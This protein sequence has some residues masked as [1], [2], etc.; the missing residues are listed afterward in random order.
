M[1]WKFLR[2]S[3]WRPGSRHHAIWAVL[4]VA[5]GTAIA[6][7]MLSVS[8]DIGDK[9]GRELRSLGAN[10][11]ITPAADSL[12]VEIGGIDY[13][14]VSEGAY[15]PDSSLPKL[16]EIFWRNNITAF[17]PF[18]YVPVRVVPQNG[19]N[20]EVTTLVGTWY[21]RPFNTSGGERFQTGVK[22]LNPSW[23]IAGS[24]IDDSA[25][26][27]TGKYCLAGKSLA[28]SLHLAPGDAV[29]LAF[30]E[31]ESRP[32][33]DQ[34]PAQVQCAI[35]GILTT[36]GEEDQQI[37]ST[38]AVA[39]SLAGLPGKTRKIQ[40][41]ALIKPEDPSSR[42]DIKAMT[43]AEYERWYCSPYISSILH[44][45]DEVLPGA[46]ARQI[47][48]VAE[49]EGKVLGKLEFLMVTLAVL[50]LVAAA[51]S[52]SSIATIRV[53]KRRQEISLMKAIGAEDRMVSLLFLAEAALQGIV[54]GAI[55]FGGGLLLARL[56][57]RMVF[58]GAL[59]VNWL[60]LPVVVLTGL[61][62][63]FAGTWGPLKVAQSYEPAVVLRGE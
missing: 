53:V 19:T 54:G 15:I 6:A 51:L 12:P 11:V 39:Q 38:L 56:I 32:P 14:P 46:S 62:V 47:S 22:V 23:Q 16:K 43:P 2:E 55:G 42:R 29:T 27:E 17:A 37:F 60:L 30:G 7:A 33:S 25:V 28:A 1:F 63:S 31:S 52:I 58:G 40:A 35:R 50:A 5:M 20:N 61:L 41:S 57:E 9:I 44:Q 34:S 59:S 26:A 45:I 18:V 24:W 48:P 13:R 8:L 21:D 10:I 36:G 3:L 4:A 49:T